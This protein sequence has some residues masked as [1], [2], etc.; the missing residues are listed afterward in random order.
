MR[1][2]KI[3]VILIMIFLMLLQLS[4]LGQ[5]RN[6][7]KIED[8]MGKTILYFS[9]HP[10]DEIYSS[11]TLAKLTKNGN[12]VYIVMLT[13]GN[14]GSLDIE[15]T[16]ERLAKI[17]KKEDEEANKVIGIPKE[18]IIWLGYDDGMLEYVP[19]KELCEVVCRLIR[20]YRPDAIFSWDPDRL[21]W[22]VHKDHHIAA[23]VTIDGARSAPYHLYF[24]NHKIYEGLMPFRVKEYFFYGSRE[25]NFKV[26]VTDVAELKYQVLCKHI[27][28][29]G[30]G[31]IKYTGPEMAPEDKE[32]YRKRVMKKDS[33]GRIYESFRRTR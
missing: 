17:R 1:T 24:P 27:S 30:K 2:K 33:D 20:K 12:T 19:E 22:K 29:M 7:D 15:M 13:S 32:R 11:G 14:G 28:Q 21:W 6:P 3:T 26:D 10:D 8:W 16:G 5:N 18:N 9:P 23:K 25:P 4:V 31:N